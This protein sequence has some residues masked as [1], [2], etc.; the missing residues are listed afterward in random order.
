MGGHSRLRFL[1]EILCFFPGNETTCV[2][3]VQGGAGSTVRSGSNVRW[4]ARHG[5]KCFR[6]TSSLDVE[7]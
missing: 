5:R 4:G 2:G 3:A 1:H 6:S 7:T